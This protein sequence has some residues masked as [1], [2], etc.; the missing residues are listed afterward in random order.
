MVHN[1]SPYYTLPA[2]DEADTSSVR[3]QLGI[4]LK[5]LVQERQF[6]DLT[7]Q[8]EGKSWEVHRV[9]LASCSPFCKQLLQCGPAPGTH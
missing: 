5:D 8:V 9:V 7:L 1:I 2:D 6:T 3:Y 4:N